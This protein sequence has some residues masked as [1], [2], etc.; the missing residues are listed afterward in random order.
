MTNESIC[1]LNTYI[2][3]SIKTSKGI[4]QSKRYHLEI[5]VAIMS[6]KYVL[7]DVRY[8]NP[9]QV[10][11]SSQ[12][13]LKNKGCQIDNHSQ[14]WI[15]VFHHHLIQLSIIKLST[16]LNINQ[17]FNIKLWGRPCRMIGNTSKKIR[18][19]GMDSTGRISLLRSHT[20]AK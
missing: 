2:I 12:I 1:S 11:T 17:K 13:K 10:V 19:T 7:R 16:T 18:M 5:K 15:T 4:S 14:A 8:R 3:Q 20:Y 9:Q 6:H